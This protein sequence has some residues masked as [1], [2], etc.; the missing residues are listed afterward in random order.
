MKI[1]YNWLKQY[2]NFDVAP[3]KVAELLTG[4][5]LEV[6]SMEPFQS[7]KGGLKGVVIAEVL[8]C[9]KHPNS[10]HLSITTVDAGY[11]TPLQVV[12]GASNVAAGQKVALAT[13]GTTLYMAD[14]EITLQKSKIRGEVSEGMICAE[15]ELGLGTSHAGILVLPPDAIVGTPASTYFNIEEDVTYT[16]GLTPNR[17]DAASHAGVARDLAAVFNNFGGAGME[18]GTQGKLVLPDVSDFRPDNETRTIPV[19]IDDP[20]A[21]P[22]YCGLTI[23]GIRVESSPDWLKN[24]L[25]AIGLRP[26]NNIVDI[27]NYILMELGQPLHAFDADKITGNTVIVKK[28]PGGTKF[29]T[30]DHVE[31]ELDSND[32]MISNAAE[33]MCMGGVFGGAESGVTESTTTVF[34]ESAWF[35]PKHIR[36]T[37]RRHGLQT[38]ASFRFERGVDPEMTVFA[39]KRAALLIREVAGGSISSGIVDV[40]PKPVNRK[41]VDLTYKNMDRLTGKVIDREVIKTILKDLGFEVLQPGDPEARI[42]EPDR[43]FSVKVPGFKVDVSREADLI[44]EVLRIYG[45]NNIEISLEV[46]ASLSY[47][48]K[49]DPGKVQNVISDYLAANGFHEIMNN[50]LT[51]S[52]YYE[53]LDEMPAGKCVR[54][55]NPISRELDVMR[56]SLLQG[57]LECVVYNQNRKN[58]DLK[59]FEFGTVYSTVPVDSF[60]EP[61]PGYHEEKHLSILMTGRSSEENWN[62]PD[63]D[64]DFYELK[65]YISGILSRLAIP[66]TQ[67]RSHSSGIYSE[68]LCYTFQ[69]KEIITIG[70]L[71]GTIRK[72]FDIRYPVYYGEINWSLL[73]P[74]I[75]SKEARYKEL[76][77]FPEVRRD[78]ALLISKEITFSQIEEVAL[79]T[80]RKLLKRVGLFDVYEGEKIATDKKS[81][82]LSFTLQDETRTLTDKDIEK[83]MERLSKAFSEKLHAVIR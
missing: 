33:P 75:P 23:S 7:V 64:T 82:A 57:G 77:K 20:E 70:E 72:Q 34:I 78:L 63:R 73:F 47:T 41:I 29:I 39:L 8:T 76:P 51:R 17:A 62:K 13:I 45:Y 53:G 36:K 27:T 71:T 69:G 3:D 9:V 12:C 5:G 61:V 44:E 56:Q 46:R 4:C 22:R 10:D 48:S 50:S 32:L 52:D 79:L 43:G 83:V 37:S 21:C 30:L 19:V 2:I 65:G 60:G 68:G 15:D 81:Y 74:L 38:D 26:I 24:R 1:S 42:T 40:Y 58:Q 66:V 11:N 14:K 59:L 54:I 35:D 80:E 18:R 67:V 16:I 25:S 28:Y 49:P 31:R 55:L 6:E